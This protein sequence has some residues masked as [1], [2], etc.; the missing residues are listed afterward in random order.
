MPLAHT[1]G[2]LLGIISVDEPVTG[3]RPGD[4][5]LQVLWAVAEHAALALQSARESA[6]AD[7]HRQA[8]AHL[9]TVSSRLTETLA[10]DAVLQSI[11]DGIAALGFQRV[12]I[13]LPD[14]DTN[15]LVPRHAVGW[16]MDDPAMSVPF[17]IEATMRLL[18]PEFDIAGLLP[19]DHTAGACA[20]CPPATTPTGRRP[21]AAARA[22]G[23]TTGWWCRCGRPRGR[24]DGC[25]LGRRPGR[26]AA[27]SAARCCRPCGCSRTRQRPHWTSARHFEEM[28]YL[29]EH[30]PLTRLLNRRAFIAAGWGSR[31]PARGRYHRPFALVMCDLDGFKGLNDRHGHHGR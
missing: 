14:P 12:S 4:E 31:R 7:A 27:A 18:E 16:L 20:R 11:C 3:M 5:H 25:D 23:T 30:D 24:T 2:H 22:A 29:A 21:T 10:T 9:L 13:D 19:A 28:R 26:P 6:L 17:S 8:L 1:E 15:L